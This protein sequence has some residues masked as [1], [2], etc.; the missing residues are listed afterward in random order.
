MVPSRCLGHPLCCGDRQGSARATPLCFPAEQ[1]PV[2]AG[3]AVQPKWGM[4]HESL[5][6]LKSVKGLKS[7]DSLGSSQRRA[8]LS[9]SREQA[10]TEEEQRGK[11]PFAGKSLCSQLSPHPSSILRSAP[12]LTAGNCAASLP[13]WRGRGQVEAKTLPKT[14]CSELGL[15]F[16]G[17]TSLAESQGAAQ[18]CS[19]RGSFSSK[20]SS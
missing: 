1:D 5:S 17:S 4:Y 8:A 7:H 20:L 16:V 6:Q 13:A 18:L 15:L 3:L 11:G 9:F 12:A 19:A 14:C 2:G 10:K